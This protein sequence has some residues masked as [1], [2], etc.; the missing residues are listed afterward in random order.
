MGRLDDQEAGP[1]MAIV[2]VT[3]ALVLMLAC[4][5]VANLLLA[6]GVS[7]ARELAVRAALG[8]S[9]WRIGRQLLAES[10][11]LA[12]LG[13]AAGIGLAAVL[14][15]AARAALPELLLATMPN[16]DELGLDRVTLAYTVALCFV[17]SLV[18]GSVP[19]WRASR[20]SFQDG[21][22]EGAATGGSRGTRR[23]RGALVVAE[24]AL[25]A[26][27]L[28]AAGLLVR[29]YAG[30]QR[31]D[32][33]FRPGGVLTMTLSLPEYR[34]PDAP[35]R[36][37][38][39]ER[40]LERITQVPGVRSAGFVNVLP[41]STYDRGARL[42]VE[43]APPPEPGRQPSVSYRVAGP[44]Y[45]E[46][47]GIPVVEGRTFDG[48]DAPDGPPVALVNRALVR[49]YLGGEP[50]VG[51]RVR[52]GREDAPWATIVGVVGDVHH[53]QLTR[54]PDPE[55]YV[56]LAQAPPALLMLA[57]RTEGRPEEQAASVRAAIQA[58][59]PAQ[60]VYHVKTMGQLVS[61]SLLAQTT[62]AALMTLFSAL[63]LALA[64]VGVYGVVAYGVSQQTREFGLRIALGATPRD[65]L[66]LVLRQGLR[67]VG[68]GVALGAVSA[69]A[70]TRL[71]GGILYGVG[72]ADPRTY[73]GVVG[74]LVATGLL[75]ASVPAWRASR[76]TPVEALRVD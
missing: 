37:Q 63:A 1:T 32:P 21:L 57:V 24:V 6:R 25:S 15:N 23:L 9:A 41:F 43:G 49:R 62:S 50:S 5:N 66:A 38:F 44:G 76:V 48:R 14:L 19:A 75:A 3:A 18:F 55:V 7:R 8:A 29:S 47:L 59:D 61:D 30:L 17:T 10:L 28:V 45:L 56:P 35:Q 33:G 22:R 40:A 54:T 52:L 2:L 12:L 53:A 69:L 39:A 65:V 64:A 42:T 73:L 20:P 74:L 36:L 16:V 71:M 4:A 31:V 70:A 13:G 27:L 60:P 34:Y 68:L 58:V 46:T 67:L 11:L 72:P 26:L 51:R